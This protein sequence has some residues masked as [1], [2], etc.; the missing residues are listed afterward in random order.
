MNVQNISV[1]G[2][3]ASLPAHTLV[4]LY[5]IVYKCAWAEEA[6]SFLGAWWRE[7][8]QDGAGEVPQEGM[9]FRMG[10]KEGTVIVKMT[11]Q[12]GSRCEVSFEAVSASSSTSP[13]GVTSA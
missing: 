1:R 12:S 9:A 10:R 7:H 8:H 2:K 11:A 5:H 13:R 6:G 3:L 4:E